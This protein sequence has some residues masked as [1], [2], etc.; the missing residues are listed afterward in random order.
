MNA[1]SNIGYKPWYRSG[2][3]GQF[4]VPAGTSANIFAFGASGST[5]ACLSSPEFSGGGAGVFAS[6]SLA[7]TED[8]FYQL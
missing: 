3:F 1:S 5:E 6:G 4:T 7:V 8:K 2:T